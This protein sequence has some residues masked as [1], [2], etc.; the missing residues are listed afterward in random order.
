MKPVLGEQGA[1]IS[2][3]K[4]LQLPYAFS[5]APLLTAE[6]FAKQCGVRG[7][8]L[9]DGHLEALHRAGALVPLFRVG[10]SVGRPSRAIDMAGSRTPEVD[11]STVVTELFAAAADGRVTDPAAEPYRRWPIKQHRMLWPSAA[12]G[13]LWSPHQLL[14]L[15]VAERLL[16]E[17][18]YSRDAV[19]CRFALDR[20]TGQDLEVATAWRGLAIALTALEAKYLPRITQTVHHELDVWFR[21]DAEFDPV[22]T[23]T[24][25]GT[26]AQEA[27]SQAEALSLSASWRDPFGPLYDIVRRCDSSIWDDLTG[28]ARRSIDER[29]AAEML[30]L[31]TDDLVTVRAAS[32]FEEPPLTQVPLRHQRISSRDAS[33]DA[34]LSKAGI[35]PFPSLVLA[36]EGKTEMTLMP[37]VFDLL[38][39]D[40]GTNR[41]LLVDLHGAD[42]DPSLLATHAMPK[43]GKQLAAAA[44][45]FLM[46]D[47]P[48]ARVLVAADPEGRYA[49][50]QDRAALRDRLIKLITEEVPEDFRADLLHPSAELVEVRTWPGLPF[51]FAHFSDRELATALRSAARLPCPW[52]YAELVRRVGLQRRCDPTPDLEDAWKG[53]RRS[54]LTKVKVA[55]ALWPTLERRIRRA[56]AKGRI[57]D[58]PI[59]ALAVRANELASMRRHGIGLRRESQQ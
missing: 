48:V 13:F 34:A 58:V 37:K 29:L 40:H 7:V 51:E 10:L 9:I 23:M 36:L 21:H 19:A 27:R 44:G 6:Q 15:H 38:G 26:T 11:R 54:G 47:R 17:M 2:T 1:E 14:G 50:E 25:L 55:E 46:V 28:D 56:E 32:T 12:S 5:Q 53:W 30:F 24:W 43:I 3:P 33:L 16:P 42:A 22:E 57:S 35:S 41:M 45:P 8:T 4:L 31:W 59:L 18:R 39:I 52:P 49:T 20:L